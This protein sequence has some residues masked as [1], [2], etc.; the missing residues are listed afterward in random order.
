ILFDKQ[1]KEEYEKIKSELN[2]LINKIR[3]KIVNKKYD[4]ALM[5][6]RNI[7]DSYPKYP[8]GYIIRGDVYFA[9]QKYK[10][11]LDDYKKALSLS[12]NNNKNFNL[13]LKLANTEYELES[14]KDSIDYYLK[15][16]NLKPN[17]EY[18]YYQLTGAY[19]FIENFNN[20]LNCVEKYTKIS[21]TKK[22]K[23]S[24]YSKW[25]SILNKY[26]ENETIRDLKKILKELS[27]IQ[28]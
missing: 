5:D 2:N 21:K 13:Y 4:E 24:D 14:Y 6:S 18:A 3:E 8:N 9:M 7:I 20:A 12:S 22:I 25:T 16:I 10:Q 28:S 23:V 26:T 17:Y 15:V 11:A 27:F 19:I 1:N